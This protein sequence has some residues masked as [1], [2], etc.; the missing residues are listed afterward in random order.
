MERDAVATERALDSLSRA[1]AG[2]RAAGSAADARAIEAARDGAAAR[3]AGLRDR[4]ARLTVR[5]QSAGVV[6][7]PR[8]HEL[9]G[10]AVAAGE[11]VVLVGETDSLELRIPVAGAGAG[12][13]RAGQTVWL[14]PHSSYSR[15]RG[16]VDA[17]SAAGDPRDGAV[18]VRVRVPAQPGLIA[19]TSGQA[20]IEIAGSNLWGSFWWGVRRHI[21]T[22][23]F[24]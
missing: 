15:I 7:S 11:S 14:L 22:D 18:E 20:R 21:R 5:A 13:L 10:R 8:P 16:E 6:L 23:L 1:V 2:A 9:T 19:G 17:V 12:S 3:A 24:L 4:L